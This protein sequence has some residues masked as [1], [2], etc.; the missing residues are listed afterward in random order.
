MKNRLNELVVME[1]HMMPYEVISTHLGFAIRFRNK[2]TVQEMIDNLQEVLENDAGPP[3]LV[4]AHSTLDAEDNWKY[5]DWYTDILKY[6]RTDLS[7][8]E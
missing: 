4:I 3:Y 7:K 2:E 6:E 1:K 8:D 5:F